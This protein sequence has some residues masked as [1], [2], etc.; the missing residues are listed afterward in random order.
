M[1]KYD[2]SDYETHKKHHQEFIRELKEFRV[3]FPN[4]SEE[5]VDELYHNMRQWIKTHILANDQKLGEFLIQKK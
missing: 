4:Y 3:K 5:A 2:Y 1:K